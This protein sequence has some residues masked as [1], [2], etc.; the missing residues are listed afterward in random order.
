MNTAVN[1]TPETT[2]EPP[3]KAER[4]DFLKQ[5][6]AFNEANIRAYDT[7]A[8]ISLAAFVLSGN[9]LVSIVN[10]ACSANSKVILI[11][12]FALFL[13]VIANY[14][15]VLWPVRPFDGI[16]QG[17]ASS[18]MFY[19]RA[20]LTV[21][22][23]AYLKKLANLTI[24]PELSGEAIK[25]SSIRSVKA[26]RFTRALVATLTAYVALAAAFFGPGRCAF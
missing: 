24:E 9:P 23:D 19:V 6:I 14:L 22:G 25:L 1:Q 16:E 15:L 11:L 4:I 8:Q 18:D 13:L 3:S 21:A 12:F 17:L 10:S 2:A 20:P 26:R 5:V 7:K